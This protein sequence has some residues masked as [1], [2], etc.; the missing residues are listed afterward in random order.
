MTRDE[1]EGKAKELKGRIK[2]AAGDLA[3]DQRLH[4]EGVADE[5]EGEVQDSWGRAK[6]KVGNAVEDL[7]EA[8]K[9]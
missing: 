4:D 5:A 9:K 8:I 3:D 1:I 2:Q 7:G 6:R